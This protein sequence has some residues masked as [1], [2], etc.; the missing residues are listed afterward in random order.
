MKLDGEMKA[1]SGGELRNKTLELKSR[2][3]D[4]LVE[5]VAVVRE[6]SQRVLNMK[7]YKKQLIGGVALHQGRVAEMKMGEG[8][9][10]VATCPAYLNALT[11]NGVHIVTINDYLAEIDKNKMGQVHDFLGLTTGVILN[12]ME[13][14]ERKEAYQCDITYGTNSVDLII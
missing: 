11:G 3:E 13:P 7:H 1:L 4:I 2:L 10:L 5:A 14:P 8:K 6:A 9:T 12:E